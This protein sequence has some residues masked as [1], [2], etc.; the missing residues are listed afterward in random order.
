MPRTFLSEVALASGS[1]ALGVAA[2]W[3]GGKVGGELSLAPRA[4]EGSAPSCAPSSRGRARAIAKT[5]AAPIEHVRLMLQYDDDVSSASRGRRSTALTAR[6]GSPREGGAASFTATRSTCCGSCPRAMA[7][8]RTRGSRP[9]SLHAGARRL[10]PG[11]SFALNVLAGGVSA[12]SVDFLSTLSTSCARSSSA[13]QAPD[14]AP[15]YARARDVVAELVR[16]PATRGGSTPFAAAIAGKS[17]VAP[18]R[19]SPCTARSRAQPVHAKT[20]GP[21]AARAKFAAAQCAALAAREASYPATPC[22]AGC[23][24]TRAGPTRMKLRPPPSSQVRRAAAADAR[25]PDGERR[26]PAR[27][28]AAPRSTATGASARC[29]AARGDEWAHV[30]SA[31]T[32]APRRRSQRPRR[33]RRRESGVPPRRSGAC[34]R[35]GAARPPLWGVLG[36]KLRA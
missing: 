5:V 7:T 1:V 23:R 14:G 9:R 3:L 4:A 16:A 32:L 20:R 34:S 19:S 2:G 24:R 12:L 31:L 33:G 13:R 18:R 36:S 25:R 29:T 27:S 35:V 11:K 26:R 15:A 28:T 30:A 17:P 21:G 8:R 6:G 10:G 22:A